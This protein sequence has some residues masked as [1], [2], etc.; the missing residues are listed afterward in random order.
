MGKSVHGSQ[1]YLL[2]LL[3][4]TGSICC[5]SRA[6]IKYRQIWRNQSEVL[7]T[8]TLLRFNGNCEH[9]I[10][11]KGMLPIY[12]QVRLERIIHV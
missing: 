8:V 1:R 10:L 12:K 7:S 4:T 3:C 11:A 2:L 9:V 5:F 6:H